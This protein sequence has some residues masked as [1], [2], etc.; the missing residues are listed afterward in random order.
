MAWAGASVAAEGKGKGKGESEG[1]RG[2]AQG[3]PGCNTWV[4]QD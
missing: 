4:L 3:C 2:A 1:G